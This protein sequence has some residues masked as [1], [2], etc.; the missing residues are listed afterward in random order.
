MKAIH[1]VAILYDCHSIRSLIPFLFEGRLPDFNVGTD[2]GRTCA[3]EIETATFEVCAKAEGYTSI[4]NGR[5]KG[6]WTTR[7][8]GKP[9]TGVHAIQMEL[10]QVSHLSTEVPPF[11]LDADKAARLRI[12]LKDILQRIEALASTPTR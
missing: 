5:F 2:M 7:H 1:G 4:L 6:G 12:H 11:D 9:E 3:K 8:Y 10:A